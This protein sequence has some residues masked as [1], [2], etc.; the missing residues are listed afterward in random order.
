MFDNSENFAWLILFVPLIAAGIITVFTRNDHRLSGQISIGAALISFLITL[1]LFSFL[2]SAGAD[3]LPQMRS[4]WLAIGDDFVVDI[5]LRLDYLSL[6][7]ALIV[8]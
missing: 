4:T 8:T 3:Q 1:V 2:R 6:T 7:M 5:G